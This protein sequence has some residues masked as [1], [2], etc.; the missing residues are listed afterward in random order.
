[1]IFLT[2]GHQMPFD[3]L[4]RAVDD[5]AGRRIRGEDVFAQIGGGTYKPRNFQFVDHLSPEDFNLWMEHAGGIVAHAG[6][7]TIIAALKLGKPLL[8]LPRLSKYGETRN[9]HQVPTARH[10]ADSG[11]VLAAWH[12]SEVADLLDHLESF[13]PRGTLDDQASP[14]LINRLHR[15]AFEEA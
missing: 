2:V 10:F 13:H 4:V 6:T 14:E 5:W 9:D 8:V 12:E 7:G 15:F 1:M 3:R 11:R